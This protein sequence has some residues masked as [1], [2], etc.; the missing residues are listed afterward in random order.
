[1]DLTNYITLLKRHGLLIMFIC[2]SATLSTALITNLLPEKYEARALVLVRPDLNITLSPSSQ[3][4]EL[5]SFPVGGVISKVEIPSNTYIQMIKSYAMAEKIVSRLHLDVVREAPAATGYQRFKGS[6][7]KKL[8]EIHL[9][10]KQILLHGRILGPEPP[11]E[12]A[13]WQFQENITLTAIKDAYQFEIKY[14]ATDPKTAA[15]VANTAADLFLEYMTELNTAHSKRILGVLDEKLRSSES[16]LAQAQR[17]L[18]VFKEMNQIVSFDEETAEQIKLISDLEA[19]LERTD[20]RLAGLLK[21]LTPSNPKV[22]SVQ[23]EK[24]RLQAALRERASASSQLPEKERRLANLN[25][26]V[27]VAD[28]LYQ[29]LKKAHEEAQLQSRNNTS[30]I[31]V[32]S[33]AVPAFYPSRPLRYQYVGIALLISLLIAIITT[34]LLEYLNTTLRSIEDVETRLQLPVLAAIPRMGRQQGRDPNTQ[35]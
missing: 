17:A 7:K 2:T 15:D 12:R 30:E 34:L 26:N 33:Q 16:D 6:L 3:S 13:I 32:V 20:V 31:R 29:L 9:V 23:A 14:A 24:D 4:K 25:L 5:L 21:G 11:F 28:E 18:R 27:Q 8:L 1:M 22:Q 10:T 19:S 35:S